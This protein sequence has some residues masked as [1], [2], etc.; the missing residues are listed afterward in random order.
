MDQRKAFRIGVLAVGIAALAGRTWWS[1]QHAGA[2]AAV[3]SAGPVIVQRSGERGF[4]LGTLVFAPCELDQR[5]SA[6]APVRAALGD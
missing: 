2:P 6:E 1:A 5:N 3:S 4:T